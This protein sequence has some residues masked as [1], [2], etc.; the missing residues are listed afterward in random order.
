MRELQRRSPQL[1]TGVVVSL[2]RPQQRMLGCSAY[3]LQDTS[4]RLDSVIAIA[5][6]LS[7]AA[8]DMLSALIAIEQRKIP[9]WRQYMAP[10]SPT[11][12]KQLFFLHHG[13]RSQARVGC[14]EKLLLSGI[15]SLDLGMTREEIR[16]VCYITTS[17]KKTATGKVAHF[18]EIKELL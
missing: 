18:E 1:R 6:W 13:C 5:R 7:I 9:S 12:S 16:K 2:L 8:L 17:R 4:V 14:T 3:K 11:Q 15:A 10:I